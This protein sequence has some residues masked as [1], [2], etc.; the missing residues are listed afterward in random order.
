[1]RNE[2]KKSWCKIKKKVKNTAADEGSFDEMCDADLPG[3][4]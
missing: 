2:K 1:M 4:L 3:N